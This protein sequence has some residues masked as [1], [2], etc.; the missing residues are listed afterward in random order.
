[1]TRNRVHGA[2]HAATVVER[3]DGEDWG[4]AAVCLE[5]GVECDAWGYTSDWW[6][7]RDDVPPCADAD[8]IARALSFLGDGTLH[9][10]FSS[11]YC[12]AT[13][14]MAHDLPARTPAPRRR[15]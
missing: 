9:E 4:Y 10:P 8:A 7:H 14:V 13:H 1:M 15:K 11:N 2:T 5:T 12:D 6:H 3:T